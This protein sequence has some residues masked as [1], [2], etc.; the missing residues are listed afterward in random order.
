MAAPD[1]NQFKTTGGVVNLRPE[2]LRF[3]LEME[4]QMRR[5][6]YAEGDPTIDQLFAK[7]GWQCGN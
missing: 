4:D 5:Q 6:D 7:L 3:A 1:P 2:I